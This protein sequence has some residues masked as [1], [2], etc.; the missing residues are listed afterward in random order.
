MSTLK[1]LVDPPNPSHSLPRTPLPCPSLPPSLFT[2]LYFSP[3]PLPTTLAP[4][5]LNLRALL[6]AL[7]TPLSDPPP[8]PPIL[9][10]PTT[11]DEIN[12]LADAQ[13]YNSEVGEIR[14]MVSHL[15]HVIDG[16]AVQ[17]A[18][19][20]DPPPKSS[21]V[22]GSKDGWATVSSLVK[23][24]VPALSAGARGRKEHTQPGQHQQQPQHSY[25]SV[26][27]PSETAPLTVTEHTHSSLSNLLKFLHP[28][29]PPRPP[30]PVTI[31]CVDTEHYCCSAAMAS[32]YTRLTGTVVTL[33]SLQRLCVRSKQS[34]PRPT[35]QPR[36]MSVL[37]RLLYVRERMVGK[38]LRRRFNR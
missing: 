5:L 24:S 13:W 18:V 8:I 26:M 35:A 23:D 19:Q 36:P 16:T 25:R 20:S 2:A 28:M 29:F 32:D 22:G 38:Q 34:V 14:G 30:A 12:A 7:L 1:Y 21:A 17:S 11:P 9:Q 3:H 10:S 6:L 27:R 15:I 31:G 37:G 4:H 33:A